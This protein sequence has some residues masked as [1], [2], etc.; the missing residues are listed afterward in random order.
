ML[1]CEG[2]DRDSRPQVLRS[3]YETA[4]NCRRRVSPTNFICRKGNRA[5]LNSAKKPCR[6]SVAVVYSL[7]CSCFQRL[8]FGQF[9]RTIIS[10]RLNVNNSASNIHVKTAVRGVLNVALVCPPSLNSQEVGL[11]SFPYDSLQICRLQCMKV[12]ACDSSA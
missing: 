2:S 7:I 11:D 12:H 1:L 8:G 4:F 9:A 5:E 3:K 10:W 6:V